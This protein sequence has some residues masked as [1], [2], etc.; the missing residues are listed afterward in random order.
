M[1]LEFLEGTCEPHE[2][3]VRH[4]AGHPDGEKG[5]CH[6]S[7]GNTFLA[8]NHPDLGQD[9]TMAVCWLATLSQPD[10]ALARRESARFFFQDPFPSRRNPVPLFLENQHWLI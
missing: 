9:N 4:V 8:S 6:K 10:P 5:P 1:I 7:G 3:D 2:G